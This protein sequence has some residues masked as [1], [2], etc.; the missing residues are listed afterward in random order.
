MVKVIKT[1]LSI[2][3]GEDEKDYTPI[4]VNRRCKGKGY[5]EY[6][7]SDISFCVSD[8]PKFENL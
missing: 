5:S 7:M 1:S 8:F 6:M 3:D 2:T 4:G